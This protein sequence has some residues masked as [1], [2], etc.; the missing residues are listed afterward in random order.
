[1]NA[2]DLQIWNNAAFDNGESE[3]SS[4][5][6]GSWCPIKPVIVNRSGSLDSASSKENQSPVLVK[7]PISVKSPA[8][9]KSLHPNGA[10]GNSKLPIK[11]LSKQG[12]ADNPVSKSGTEEIIRGKKQIDTEIEDIEK[13][14]SRLSSR[15]QVLRLE[16]ADQNG[17]MSEKRGRVVPARFME[18]KENVKSTTEELK[19]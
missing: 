15:L 7:S 6:R 3:V 17:R 1:M 9:I 5:I 19:K 13:E 8:K 16:K 2:T 4:T 14:I 11:P 12:L 18:Q 10:I